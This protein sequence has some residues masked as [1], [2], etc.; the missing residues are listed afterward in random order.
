M[1]LADLLREYFVGQSTFFIFSSEFC[2]LDE[3]IKNAFVT[4]FGESIRDLFYQDEYNQ[5]II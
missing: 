1:K 2:I 3:E 5:V 4:K